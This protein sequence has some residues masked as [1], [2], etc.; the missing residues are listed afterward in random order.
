[1]N[2]SRDKFNFRIYTLAF[3]II[4]AINLYVF[5]GMVHSLLFASI[6]AGTFY[7]FYKK[8]KK[9]FNLKEEI[10]ATLVT[11]MIFFL[12]VITPATQQ[13]FKPYILL[14]RHLFYILLIIIFMRQ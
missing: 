9:R 4:I 1:M 7:P 6:T 10:A 12:I 14:G 5:K 8:I 13:A 3:F 2:L 11:G